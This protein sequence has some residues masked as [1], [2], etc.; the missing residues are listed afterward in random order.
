ML[1][2]K[3]KI[4]KNPWRHHYPNL[5]DMIYSSRDI[6]QNIL[7]L[8]ILGHFLPFYPPKNPKNQISEKWRNLLEISSFRTCVP[9]I[10]I[11]WCMVPEIQNETQNFLSFWTIFCPFT[12]PPPKNQKKYLEILS[13]YTYICTTNEDHMI[14]GS[15]NISATGRNFCHFG[16]FF[17]LLPP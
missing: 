12:T 2:F 5:D 8:I 10:T 3:K 1:L 6:E 9:K 17:A 15:W 7:K 14:Y 16:P 4:K 13:F 11:L